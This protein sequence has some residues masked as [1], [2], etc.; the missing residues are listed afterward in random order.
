MGRCRAT[1]ADGLRKSLTKRSPR[2]PPVIGVAAIGRGLNGWRTGDSVDPWHGRLYSL[3]R[4]NLPGGPLGLRAWCRSKAPPL[5]K[6]SFLRQTVKYL[7][8]IIGAAGQRRGPM[9]HECP[10]RFHHQTGRIASQPGWVIRSS[11]S[12]K[13]ASRLAI[14]FHQALATSQPQMAKSQGQFELRLTLA[15]QTI[16]GFRHFFFLH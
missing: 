11:L 9:V 15:F 8:L 12:Q 14:D 7:A 1:L 6:E 13:R 10:A 5:R 16:S 2:R 3:M 4:M